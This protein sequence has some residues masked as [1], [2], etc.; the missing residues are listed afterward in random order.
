MSVNFGPLRMIG[1]VAPSSWW[2]A[3]AM[4]RF[5]LEK[6]GV[7]R[8]LEVGAGTGAI[9]KVLVRKMSRGQTCDVVEIFPE[10][11][12]ILRLRFFD[13]KML[14]IHCDDIRNFNRR[15]CYDLILCSLPFNAF[16]PKTAMEVLEQLVKLSKPSAVISYYEYRA[17]KTFLPLVFKKS[18][19]QRF[20]ET[21]ALVDQF[22]DR[23]KFDEQVINLNIPPAVVH[24][25][26]IDN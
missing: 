7:K 4:T 1:A 17:L 14:A 26:S 3:Q 21:R 8:I 9:T 5:V 20:Y 11:A 25:L 2:L 12:S 16:H 15:H 10:L 18:R 13:R 23:Y 6:P 19:L 24:Y 22:T